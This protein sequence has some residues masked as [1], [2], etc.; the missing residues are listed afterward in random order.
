[1]RTRK[2]VAVK[3]AGDPTRPDMRTTNSTEAPDRYIVP[4]EVEIRLGISP[5]TR[6]RWTARGLLKAYPL[7]PFYRTGVSYSQEGNRNGSRVRYSR[8]EVED[9]AR[10]IR[11]GELGRSPKPLDS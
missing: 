4:R 6:R 11:E 3:T 1:M 10:R 2:V 8:N 9:L 7:G 5:S